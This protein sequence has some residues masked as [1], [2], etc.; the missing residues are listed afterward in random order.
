MTVD[1][2]V[3]AMLDMMVEMQFPGLSAFPP[4]EAREAMKAMNADRGPGAPMAEIRDLTVPGPAG[5]IPVRVYRPV[6]ETA[7]G[8]VVY[9]H[10]G[11]WVLGGIDTHDGSCRELAK[12]S[13]AVVASVD[14]RLAPEHPFPAAVDDSFA[15]LGWLAE[16]AGSLG[17]TPGRVVLAGDSAGGNLTAVCA[18][19]ARD[20]GGP[21]LRLQLMLYPV[22]DAA[23]DTSSYEENAEGYLL[24]RADM[25]YFFA[26]YV[27]DDH[28]DDW[29]LAP[30]RAKDLSGLPPAMVLTAGNDPLRDEG[31]AYAERLREA[32]VKVD[33]VRYQTLIHGF[34]GMFDQV[35]EADKAMTVAAD[36]VRAALG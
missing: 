8:L 7:P 1:P 34:F 21:D 19:L 22:T 32:G 9:L 29:R 26:H 33:A 15:A 17:A 3:R 5:D 18:L 27:G 30:L 31:E 10:G 20:A 4:P 24:T 23:M 14:Y 2:Q 35:D 16:H 13:G 25:A 36:A 11:G 6:E 12:R 28:R